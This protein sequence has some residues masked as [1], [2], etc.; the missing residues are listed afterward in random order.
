MKK[1]PFI[2]I[3]ITT[4]TEK[5]AKRIAEE[6]LNKKK[7]ACVNIIKGIN[8]HFWWKGKIESSKEVLL[9]AKTQLKLFN[10][11]VKLV[12]KIHSYEIPEII[13]LPLIDSSKDYLEWIRASI[14][15]KD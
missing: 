15:N 3:F 10:D 13:A 7:V 2:V 11:I 6:L 5:N 8:S 14:K 9:V 12:K 4:A 1:S